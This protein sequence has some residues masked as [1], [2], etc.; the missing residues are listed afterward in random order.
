MV[1]KVIAILLL[2]VLTYSLIGFVLMFKIM[3]TRVRQ[4]MQAQI[5]HDTGKQ[6]LTVLNYNTLNRGDFSDM[7]NG[8]LSYKG[9]RYDVVKQQKLNNGSIVFYCIHDAVE[10]ALISYLSD[11]VANTLDSQSHK[12]TLRFYRFMVDWYMLSSVKYYTAPLARAK[13]S[14]IAAM[15]RL[16]APFIG[17]HAPP[18]KLG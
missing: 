18:P 14:L 16:D 6:P 5:E 13:T 9:E 3:V 4:D 11:D 10:T 7:A 1:K 15:Q 12:N 2:G 8:E 17:L